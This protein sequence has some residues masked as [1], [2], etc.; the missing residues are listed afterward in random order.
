MLSVRF[1]VKQL[2]LTVN[3]LDLFKIRGKPLSTYASLISMIIKKTRAKLLRAK[4]ILWMKEL[5]HRRSV[6]P[7]EG[8]VILK[9]S[10]RL[11]SKPS[12]IRTKE[13]MEEWRGLK[14]E[15]LSAL[16]PSKSFE[17]PQNPQRWW[18]KNPLKKCKIA[19]NDRKW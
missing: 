18:N 6:I 10:L 8:W 7:R 13:F 17:F 9:T 12:E 1:L 15:R 3:G 5:K 19:Q 11:Q 2:I 4:N 14:L 16:A